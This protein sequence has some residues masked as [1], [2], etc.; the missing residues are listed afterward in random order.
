MQLTDRDTRPAPCLYAFK[1]ILTFAKARPAQ[2]IFISTSI[3]T[4]GIG[5]YT[6]FLT[7]LI[8]LY[9]AEAPLLFLILDLLDQ[10]AADLRSVVPPTAIAPDEAQ[11]YPTI[12]QVQRESVMPIHD[13]NNWGEPE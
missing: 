9:Q 3:V 11:H 2:M 8:H 13:N 12:G 1:D 6:F 7:V 10:I 4:A 5:T